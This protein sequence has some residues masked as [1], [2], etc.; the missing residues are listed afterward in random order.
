MS[1]YIAKPS[2]P[3]PN[4]PHPQTTFLTPNM[5]EYFQWRKG[6]LIILIFHED[7][8]CAFDDR[9]AIFLFMILG[10]FGW[11]GVVGRIVKRCTG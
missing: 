8:T 5:A 11:E 6:K 1:I 4:P 7:C 2:S 9:Y 10:V 3:P